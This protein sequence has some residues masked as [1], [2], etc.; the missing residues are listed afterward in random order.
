MHYKIL[1]NIIILFFLFIGNLFIYD[2][3]FYF[4][5]IYIFVTIYHIYIFH[6]LHKNKLF[7]FTGI[8]HFIIISLLL[9]IETYFIICD[10][11]PLFCFIAFYSFFPNFIKAILIIFTHTYILHK[12]VNNINFHFLIL[13][14]QMIFLLNLK[15]IIVLFL[16]LIFYL[17]YLFTSRIIIIIII[18]FFY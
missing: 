18:S 14:L 13:V 9:Y 4:L 6:V 15:L 16:I 17:I 1:F 2:Y 10:S 12:Y 3:N 5:L 11:N 7:Q 8:N